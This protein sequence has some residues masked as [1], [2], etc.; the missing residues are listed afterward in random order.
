MT[1]RFQ[2][3]VDAS[4][5]RKTL[6]TLGRVVKRLDR[7]AQAITLELARVMRD[8]FVARLPS[9]DPVARL[10]ADSTVVKLTSEGAGIFVEV[11]PRRVGEFDRA[12]TALWFHPRRRTELATYLTAQSPWTTDT[13]PVQLSATHGWLEARRWDR[14]D[15]ERLRQRKQ[16]DVAGTRAAIRG[17]DAGVVFRDARSPVTLSVR[18]NVR[19]MI[20]DAE[21][22]LV[23]TVR[24]ALRP[25]L[26][27]AR[28]EAQRRLDKWAVFVFQSSPA[29]DAAWAT[30]DDG[31][32]ASRF[33]EHWR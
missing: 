4:A 27:R 26:V 9:G 6:R 23:E 7:A 32:A 15:V 14:E 5:A 16:A 21:V 2:L 12:F 33:L 25:A 31:A 20:A 30:G 1:V 19:S 10:V 24:P 29:L 18:D 3:A 8:E 17:L 13:F 28:E 11:P 22:G